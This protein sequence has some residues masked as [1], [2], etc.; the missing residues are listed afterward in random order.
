M[1]D[2][3]GASNVEIREMLE[4][5]DW[6]EANELALLRTAK[7]RKIP[8]RNTKSSRKIGQCKT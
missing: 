6:W 5:V 3:I 7:S 4:Y 8:L 1:V 2:G